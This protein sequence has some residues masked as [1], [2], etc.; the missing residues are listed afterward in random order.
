MDRV[1]RKEEVGEKFGE[2]REDIRAYLEEWELDP[3]CYVPLE[4]D[5]E[6]PRVLKIMRFHEK[7]LSG[8]CG[9]DAPGEKYDQGMFDAVLEY[10]K[11]FGI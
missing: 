2:L 7:R 8:I 4:P 1:A 3:S 9:L 10:L 11:K 5:P 6:D